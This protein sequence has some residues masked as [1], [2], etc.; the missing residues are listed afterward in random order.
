VGGG[1]GKRG[2]KLIHPTWNPPP[3][4]AV[5]GPIGYGQP[6]YALGAK[7]LWIGLEG[8]DDSTRDCRNY[9]I[10]STSDPSS[11]GKEESL[12]CI[13]LADE[14]ID[15]VYSLLYEVHSTVQTR[16]RR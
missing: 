6:G 3:S 4:S 11:I 5:Q 1:E 13:R 9:G 10:H 7:G 8:I 2:G 16:D 14:D 12:G 15:L